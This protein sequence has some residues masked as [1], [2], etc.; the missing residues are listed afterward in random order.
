[1]HADIPYPTDGWVTC[2]V[3]GCTCYGTWSVDEESRPAMEHARQ[4][5]FEDQAADARDG[6][7]S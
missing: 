5:H 2:P 3:T 1:M 6:L 4:K 7:A